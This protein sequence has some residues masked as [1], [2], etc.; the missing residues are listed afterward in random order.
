MANGCMM[1]PIPAVFGAALFAIGMI[2]TAVA[3]H[4]ATSVQAPSAPA[5]EVQRPQ[6]APDAPPRVLNRSDLVFW[7]LR[8]HGP[9]L[10]RCSP[11]SRSR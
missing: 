4:T 1:E 9:P 7:T 8:R 2:V 10:A 5:N 11:P 3:L 6:R